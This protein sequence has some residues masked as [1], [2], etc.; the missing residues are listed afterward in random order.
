MVILNRK[1]Q[2]DLGTQPISHGVLYS[3]LSPGTMKE[4]AIINYHKG[5]MQ[6]VVVDLC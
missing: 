5:L 6:L 1:R 4:L 3:S 2:A